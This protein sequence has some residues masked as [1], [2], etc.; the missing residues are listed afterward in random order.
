MDALSLYVT[1]L[2]GFISKR[3]MQS[4]VMYPRR[5]SRIYEYC[6]MLRDACSRYFRWRMDGIWVHDGRVWRSMEERDFNFV[7]EK[8]FIG[9]V[10]S[11]VGGEIVKGDWLC[12]ESRLL[13][14]ALQ[15]AS[16]NE[17]RSDPSIVGFSNGVWDFRDVDH[18]VFHDFSERYPVCNLLDYAYDPSAGCP[19]WLSFLGS[20]LS[21]DNIRVLQKFFGLGIVSRRM[22]GHSVEESLWMI[23][24]GANGKSTIQDVMRG[25][26]GSPWNV[27]N[28]RLDALLDGNIDSRMRVIASIEGKLFNMCEEISE[29][30]IGRGSDMFKSLVSG[31]PQNSR[32]LKH[33]VRDISDIPYFVFSMNQQPSNPRMDDAFRRRMVVLEFRGCVRSEDMD[34]SLPQK[35]AKEYSGIRNW[36]IEGYRMLVRDGYTTRVGRKSDVPT[37]ADIEMMLENG[38]SVDV[39]RYMSSISSAAHVGHS[40]EEVRISVKAGSLYKDYEDYC[41][42]QLLVEPVNQKMF[43]RAMTRL[44]FH[45]KRAFSGWCYILYCSRD[46]R[47]YNMK[48]S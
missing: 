33:N 9:S 4:A 23:G 39:W 38:Q 7:V 16:H 32:M 37:D 36:A 28:C 20:V 2:Q 10:G 41:T 43:G 47:F 17:L 3:G 21:A 15:G 27:S 26:F 29:T 25:V 8:A 24:N 48:E 6:Q 18:P 45:R 12:N 14:Y 31:S 13:R 19:V 11:G 30:A 46:S 44:N 34:K 22:L 5:S 40:S 1:G 35:L 42:G